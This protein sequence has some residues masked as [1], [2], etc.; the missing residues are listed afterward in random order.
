MPSVAF[1][2]PGQG[3]QAVGMGADLA[4]SFPEAREVFDTADRVLGFPLSQVCWEGPEEKLRQTEYTQ[5]AIVAVSLAAWR[6]L[7]A[8]EI[9]PVMV[10]GHSV[11]EYSAVAAAGVLSMEDTLRLVRVRGLAMQASGESRPGGMAAVLGLATTEVEALCQ[12]IN[13]A[14]PGTV[15]VANVNSPDQTVISGDLEAVERSPEIARSAGAK[16]CIPLPVSGAFHSSLMLDAAS[17]LSDELDRTPFRQA[18]IPVVANVMAAPVV[19]PDEVREALRAQVASRVRWV[20]SIE[21]MVARGVTTFVEVGPGTALAGMIRKICREARV[22]NV[23]DAATL[24]RAVDGLN[25]GVA[26]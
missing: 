9:R 23:Q 20:E 22:Y 24:M 16:R 11:G 21:A 15:E 25:S 8:R 5:P 4:R 14:G 18:R 1:V 3:S 12:T 26:T 13:A 19:H 7:E 10:A 17:T 2:F 6:A